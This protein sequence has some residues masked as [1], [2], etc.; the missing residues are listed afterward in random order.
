MIEKIL[1]HGENVIEKQELIYVYILQLVN[2]K[3]YTGMTNNIDR[4]LKEHGDGRSK[5]T[6]RHLPVEIKFLARCNG[7]HEARKMELLIKARGAKKWL[8]AMR[9][10]THRKEYDIEKE[11]KEWKN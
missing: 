9:F 11:P 1:R 2:G 5:S 7:R 4:R 8:D 6:R 3:H 10:S